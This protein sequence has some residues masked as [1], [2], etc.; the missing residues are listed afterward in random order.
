MVV[1]ICYTST[2]DTA[3]LITLEFK[4]SLDHIVIL[5][6]LWDTEKTPVSK[7]KSKTTTT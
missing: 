2:Q 5:K 1:H 7:Y 6:L 4:V 3:R